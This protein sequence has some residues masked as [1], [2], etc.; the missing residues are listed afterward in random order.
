MVPR[1]EMDKDLKTQEKELTDDLNNLAKKAS[2]LLRVVLI[3]L[4]PLTLAVRTDQVS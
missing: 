1:P 2:V 3:L 4:L